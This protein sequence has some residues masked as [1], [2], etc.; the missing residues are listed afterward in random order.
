MMGLRTKINCN[1]PLVYIQFLSLT[2]ITILYIRPPRSF[3]LA[4]G[5]CQCFPYQPQNHGIALTCCVVFPILH[6]FLMI[7][8]MQQTIPSLKLPCCAPPAGRV[9]TPAYLSLSDNAISGLVTFLGPSIASTIPW[10]RCG[11]RTEKK[12]RCSHVTG[13]VTVERR[14]RNE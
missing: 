14:Q 4:H 5:A 12:K 2:Q 6:P 10:H 9:C 1:I 7:A 13:M 11:V 3:T 8:T